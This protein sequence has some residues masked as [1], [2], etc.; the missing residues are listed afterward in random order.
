ME[1]QFLEWETS[2]IYM[3]VSAHFS[4][5]LLTLVNYFGTLIFI[6]ATLCLVHLFVMVTGG[7]VANCC[8]QKLKPTINL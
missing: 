4:S 1:E 7:C 6:M 2:R 5:R 3:L 8:L